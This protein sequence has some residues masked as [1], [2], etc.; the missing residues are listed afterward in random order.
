M[1]VVIGD[2]W[3]EAAERVK[4]W[5]YPAGMD[6]PRVWPSRVNMEWESPEVRALYED[7]V[8]RPAEREMLLSTAALEGDLG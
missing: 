2:G 1:T 3:R 8:L 6:D 7:R 5:N 4:R